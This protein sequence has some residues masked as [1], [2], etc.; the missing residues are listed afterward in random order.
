[1]RI[2]SSGAHRRRLQIVQYTSGFGGASSRLVP[3]IANDADDR[4]LA[5]RRARAEPDLPAY[6]IFRAEDLPRERLID[7]RNRRRIGAIGIGEDAA[8]ANRNAHRLEVAMHRAAKVG[9]GPLAFGRDSPLDRNLSSKNSRHRAAV[10][11]C[12]RP[13]IDPGH[14]FEPR[15]TGCR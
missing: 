8:A 15:R 4:R 13:T 3:Q 9:F 2:T 14:R 7:H 6:R 10:A 1:M 5:D 12:R 11:S